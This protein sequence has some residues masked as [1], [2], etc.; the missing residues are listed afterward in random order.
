MAKS[1][2]ATV[3][4]ELVHDVALATRG[5]PRPVRGNLQSAYLGYY[6]FS[7]HTGRGLMAEGLGLVVS[8]GASGGRGYQN[9]LEARR[10]PAARVASLAQTMSGSTADWP[11]QV[12]KPQ[13]VPA[14][15][16]S[17]PTSFA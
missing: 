1:F 10:A 15:T 17:R 12:P 13:S 14:M 6:A 4:V 3:K 2:F 7:P 9:S 8:D 5:G 16:L 11:T